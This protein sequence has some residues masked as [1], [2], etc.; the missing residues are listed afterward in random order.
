MT[1]DRRLLEEGLLFSTCLAF[2]SSNRP[3]QGQRFNNYQV[4]MLNGGWWVTGLVWSSAIIG[5][6]VDDY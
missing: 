4:T 2:G 5:M 3:G 1:H 6:M